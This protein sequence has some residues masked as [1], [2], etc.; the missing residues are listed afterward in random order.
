MNYEYAATVIDVHDGDTIRVD[1][2]LGFDVQF[3]NVPLRLMGINAPELNTEAGKASRDFLS[4]RLP[5]G[6]AVVIHTVK[7]KKEKYGRYLAVIFHEDQNL[8]DLLVT[9]GHALSWDGKGQRP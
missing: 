1:I 9:T 5:D 6:T 8:N 3:R 4:T 7:D 2:D